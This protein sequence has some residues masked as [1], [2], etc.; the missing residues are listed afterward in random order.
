ML[1]KILTLLTG[2]LLISILYLNLRLYY[3]P[4]WSKTEPILNLSLY[5][6][7]KYLQERLHAGA[8]YD[9]QKIY[10]EDYLFLNALYGENELAEGFRNSIEA[11]GMGMKWKG[12]KRYLFGAL[13]IADGFIDWANSVEARAEHRLKSERN[14]RWGFQIGSVVVLG[15]ILG[16]RY[17]KPLKTS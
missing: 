16:M 17:R 14:W 11:F 15:L 9:M 5:A 1:R 3:Q 7:L 8:A 4:R 13:P 6:Q 10:P 12:Q 2:L